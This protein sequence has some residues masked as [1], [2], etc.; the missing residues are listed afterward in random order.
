MADQLAAALSGSTVFNASLS[1]RIALRGEAAT[2]SL[3]SAVLTMPPSFFELELSS[4]SSIVGYLISPVVLPAP[5]RS[6]YA[7]GSRVVRSI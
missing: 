7:G 6:I 3:F 5:V 1:T 2:L 4:T